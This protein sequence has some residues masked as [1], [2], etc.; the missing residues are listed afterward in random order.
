[1]CKLADEVDCNVYKTPTSSELAAIIPGNFTYGITLDNINFVRNVVL[2]PKRGG[3]KR[4]DD[5]HQLY[6]PLHFVLAFP[7]GE[8]GWR[9]RIMR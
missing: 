6:D 5:R 1:M 2:N 9:P 7:N 4:I 8:A 3:I